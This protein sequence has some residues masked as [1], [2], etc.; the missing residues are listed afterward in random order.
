[1]RQHSSLEGGRGGPGVG[2]GGEGPAV[3]LNS[4]PLREEGGRN[5]RKISVNVA[6]TAHVGETVLRG[7]S[8]SEYGV[9][10]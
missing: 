7:L 8:H 9:Y 10:T 5:M 6:W 4:L 2:G 3:I 1:M